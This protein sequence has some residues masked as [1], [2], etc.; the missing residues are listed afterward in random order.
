MKFARLAP[1]FLLFVPITLCHQTQC[2]QYFDGFY[3]PDDY[4]K[5]IVPRENITIFDLQHVQ[6][7]VKVR[8]H[9]NN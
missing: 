9:V 6:D 1:I 7:V 4:N 8:G 5:N 3:L 2:K